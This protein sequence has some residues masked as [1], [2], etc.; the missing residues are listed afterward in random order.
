MTKCIDRKNCFN[1]NKRLSGVT[2]VEMLV[3]LFIFTA[4]VLTFY[5]TISIG[6]VAIAGAKNHL[7]AVALANEKMEIIR[8]LGYDKIGTVGGVPSGAILG[9]ETATRDGSSYAIHTDIQYVD[10]GQDGLY[11]TDTKPNDY[12]KVRVSISWGSGSNLKSIFSLST[13]APPGL[14]TVYS[15]GILSINV[16]DSQGNGIS[17]ASVHVYNNDVSPTINFTS[18]TDDNGNI[19]RI[20]SPPADQTYY[21][22]VSKGDEYYPVR[23]YARTFSFNPVD[24]NASVVEGTINPKSIITDRVSQIN[25]HTKDPL[26]AS[27]SNINFGLVGGKKIGDS[28]VDPIGPQ[29]VFSDSSLDSGS[30]G[31]KDFSDMS[32]GSYFFTFNGPSPDYEFIHMYPS[33]N[34]K[35]Q[36]NV[37]PGTTLDETAVLADVDVNSLLVTVVDDIDS[38]P[39]ADA[40]VELVNSVRSYSVSLYTDKYGQVYFPDATG[41]LFAEGYD[42]SVSA[43]DYTS[44]SEAVNI[45]KLTKKEVK[46]TN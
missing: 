25:L 9:D 18:L 22:E 31:E 28:L 44:F 30:S 34:V 37:L 36:F 20:E 40:Q 14:E 11:P 26:G 29:Y 43:T 17:Q 46:L 6:A 2:L 23:T 35:N 45:D 32:F 15:G 41:P 13:F 42:L 10:D 5:R 7:G 21:I 3:F 19:F 1:K 24:V 33:S 38:T 27:I 4:A 16:L 8:N 39:I 12:K